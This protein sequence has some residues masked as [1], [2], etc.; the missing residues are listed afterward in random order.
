MYPF[1]SVQPP[2]YVFTLMLRICKAI[3]EMHLQL[4]PIGIYHK[5]RVTIILTYTDN[6][7][8]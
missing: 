8:E 3:C 7:F 1:F 5:T 2:Q 4:R 6:W